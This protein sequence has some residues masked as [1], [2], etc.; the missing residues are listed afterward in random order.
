MSR[1][2]ASR[3]SSPSNSARDGHPR[4]GAPP[5]RASAGAGRSGAEPALPYR[6][7]LVDPGKAGKPKLLAE[8]EP[9][10]GATEDEED[11]EPELAKAEASTVLSVDEGVARVLILFDGIENGA[12]R[13]L[14]VRLD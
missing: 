1:Q 10:Q 9:V 3:R 13:E 2:R 11:G 4:P 7:F 14:Q 8:L 12:P 5:R 6:L